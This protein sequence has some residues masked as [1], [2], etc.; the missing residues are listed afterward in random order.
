MKP[1]TPIKVGLFFIVGITV[2]LVVYE[3]LGGLDFLTRGARYVT[4]FASANGLR[5]GDP[6]RLSGVEIGAI[7]DLRLVEQAIEV[8]LRVDPETVIRADSV[9]TI[10]FTSLLGANFIDITFGSPTAAVLPPGS[11]IP[12]KEGAD[13]NTI[14]AQAQELTT[15]LNQNQQKF[16]DKLGDVMG[17]EKGGLKD[18]VS[19]LNGLLT[20]I[21]AGKG[22]LGRLATDDSLYVELK[23]SFEHLNTVAEKMARGEGTLGRLATD[24]T[25]YVR[26]T[27]TMDG[28]QE[29][30]QKIRAGEGT[31]GKLVTDD[32]LFVETKALATSL[33]SV[34]KKIE[35]GEGTL[36]KLVM[37]DA[38]YNEAIDGLHQ[39]KKTAETAEDLAPLTPIL[40]VGTT[41]F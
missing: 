32:S 16:F 14:V 7:T 25:L 36:G 34:M 21:R 22:T 26:L 4:A 24:E 17:D 41:L 40:A 10:K 29:I 5:V 11:R 19:N 1:S 23:G 37:D 13:L 38:L 12:S 3:L 20:D 9:A 31:L 15:S 27:D 18:T 30:T 33:N 6:V 39:L 35:S 2:L 28:L 8:E